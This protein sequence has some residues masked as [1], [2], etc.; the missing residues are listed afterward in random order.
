MAGNLE[1]S[2]SL[3]PCATIHHTQYILGQGNC[4]CT[5]I[6]RPY[7]AFTKEPRLAQYAVGSIYDYR[8][9]ISQAGTVSQQIA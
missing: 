6:R 9:K 5:H 7:F 2:H 3:L 8:L 1:P 4:S